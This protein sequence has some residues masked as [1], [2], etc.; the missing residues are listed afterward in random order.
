MITLNYNLGVYPINN[1]VVARLSQYDSDFTL[2]FSLYTSFGDFIIESGTTAQIRGT[3]ADGYGYSANAALDIP[4]KKVTVT[5]DVQMTAAAGD[6]TFEIRLVKNNKVLNTANFT[7]WVERAALD[8]GTITSGSVLYDLEQIVDSVSVAASAAES[9]IE[10][11][12]SAEE[13][14]ASLT[15]D[16]TLTQ[17]AQAADAKAVGDAIASGVAAKYSSGSAYAAGNYFIKD[18]ILYRAKTAIS[19]G[20][21][22][23]VGT[24]VEAA[25]LG[26]EVSTLFA[27]ILSGASPKIASDTDLKTVKTP[28]VYTLNGSYINAPFNSSGNTYG[29]LLVMPG[30]DGTHYPVQIFFAFNG[31]IYTGRFNYSGAHTGYRKLSYTDV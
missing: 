1:G 11:A 23:V 19:A 9:A 6:N 15:I 10:A 22:I 27:N 18:N 12:A 20:A 29:K 28:G 13:A 24:N 5:G 26:S 25:T 2:V 8:A 14:A 17:T 7:V 4:N 21:A 31:E 30:F 3:K 16:T